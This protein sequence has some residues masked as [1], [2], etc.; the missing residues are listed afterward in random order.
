MNRYFRRAAR[1]AH[2]LMWVWLAAAVAVLLGG[3]VFSL[4]AAVFPAL[5]L[6]LIGGICGVGAFMEQAEA[7]ACK[8][9]AEA[10]DRIQEPK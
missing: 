9:R 10:W 8:A 2:I 7:R 5:I 3:L 4:A 6:L 1:N